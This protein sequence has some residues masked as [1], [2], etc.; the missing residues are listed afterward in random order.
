MVRSRSIVKRDLEPGLLL[1]PFIVAQLVGRVVTGA[2]APSGLSSTEHAVQSSVAALGS[3]TPTELA[4]RLGV[5]PTT[6]STTI[7]QLVDRGELRRVDHPNDG[8]SYVLELTAR[9]RRT[10][11]RNGAGGQAALRRVIELL[12]GQDGEVL[13]SLR[14]LESALR[15][16]L[17]ENESGP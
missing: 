10:Q 1:E 12:E 16:Y 5:P 14:R 9:G 3:V 2:V 7:A 17:A 4:K 6:L 13:A 8:R 11:A 15:A